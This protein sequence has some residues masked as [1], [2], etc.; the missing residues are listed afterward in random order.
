V[1]VA[2]REQARAIVIGT[3]GRGKTT[4]VL[5]GSV[6]YKVLHL[7]DLPVLVIP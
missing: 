1:E 3:R 2:H 5:L 6:A 4:A 7:A